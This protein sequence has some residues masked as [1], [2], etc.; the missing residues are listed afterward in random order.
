MSIRVLKL[1]KGTCY[2]A[3]VRVDGRRITKLF[4]RKG[5][6]DKWMR[7]SLEKRDGGDLKVQN[8]PTLTEFA[9]EWMNYRTARITPSTHKLHQYLLRGQIL[10]K[11]GHLKLDK[12]SAAHV[13]IVLKDVVESGLSNRRANMA[14][15][16]IQKL[17][18][19]AISSYGYKIP[20]PTS[21][22]SKLKERPKKLEFWSHEEVVCFL[23]TVE[24]KQP[25]NLPIMRFLLNTGAR[26]GEAFALQW[27]DV[28][29]EKGYVCIRRTV[30]RIHHTTQE[31]TKGNKIRY[32]GLNP[33][34]LETLK[35]LAEE[36]SR[37]FSKSDLVF[38]N[39]AGKLHHPSSFQRRCF[40]KCVEAAGVRKVR[41]HDL[42]HTFAAHFVM[43]GGSIYDLKQ[44]LGHSDIKMTE[45]YAHLAP[46]YLKSRT[47][48]V[49]FA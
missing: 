28:D 49:D 25:V 36:P 22:V 27:S 34:L 2:Q 30:D 1:K 17:Y 38:P 6:A 9:W 42:R 40:D 31:T 33:A 21:K 5:D 48:L 39:L 23:K 4:D 16:V 8:I 46:D 44:I 29:L 15:G 43:N 14:L 18:N 41:I 20:N 37:D 26:I 45:R 12:I 7:T 10:P 32:V 47:S 13:E 3:F 24:E 35:T 19:D 11:I